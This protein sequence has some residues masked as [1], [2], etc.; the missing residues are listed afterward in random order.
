MIT[1]AM[2]RSAHGVSFYFAQKGST[3]QYQLVSLIMYP[4]NVTSG[5]SDIL[6]WN[7]NFNILKSKRK[8]K[9]SH[10]F[11]NCGFHVGL[12]LNWSVS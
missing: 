7:F 5:V 6:V 8:K 10:K 4:I 9:K 3:K 1:S 12:Y 2:T 11:L